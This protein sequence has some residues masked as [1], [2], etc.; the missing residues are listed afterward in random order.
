MQRRA[1]RCREFCCAMAQHEWPCLQASR[2]RGISGSA[3]RITL[4][5]TLRAPIVNE[6]SIDVMPA[7]FTE[8]G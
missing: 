6:V 4:N 1:G 8:D 5:R 7:A 3:A 2:A